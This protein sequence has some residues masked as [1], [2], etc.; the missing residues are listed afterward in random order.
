MPQL[1][2][3]TFPSQLFWLMVC[4]LA[5]YFILSFVA[6]PKISHVLEARQDALESKI[7]KAST[8]REQAEG[9]LAEYESTL[10]QARVDAQ[11]RYKLAITSASAQIASQQK[12]LLDKLNNKLHIAEQELYRTRIEV[13]AQ[14]HAVAIE[15]AIGILKKLTGRTYSPTELNYERE[16]A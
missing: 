8:Y 13:G 4:F 7:N 1:D 11:Q 9:L 14:M 12:D 3:S 6:V 2:I 5:L 10:A 16:G 15:V